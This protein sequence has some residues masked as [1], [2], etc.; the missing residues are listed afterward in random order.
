MTFTFKS[1]G[2]YPLNY[3]PTYCSVVKGHKRSFRDILEEATQNHVKIEV[4]KIFK[5]CIQHAEKT[6]TRRMSLVREKP[7]GDDILKALAEGDIVVSNKTGYVG[8]YYTYEVSWEPEEESKK[9][10]E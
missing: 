3:E 7:L 8:S 10:D 5:E 1:I 2:N 6:G 9:S 4:C